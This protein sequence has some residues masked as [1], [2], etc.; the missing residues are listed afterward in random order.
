MITA[1]IA[2]SIT[3]P[4]TAAPCR[5]FM[6]AT[7]LRDAI[8]C[9]G[10]TNAHGDVVTDASVHRYC[11]HTN[12][13]SIVDVTPSSSSSSSSLSTA[14]TSSSIAVSD[15]SSTSLPLPSRT[16]M[17]RSFSSHPGVLPISVW[18]GVLT[19]QDESLWLFG[20]SN[21]RSGAAG[22]C[23]QWWELRL[24]LDGDNV[25]GR[26]GT[27]IP[28]NQLRGRPSPRFFAAAAVIIIFACSS[29]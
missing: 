25:L 17:I 2:T 13:W 9:F 23:D 8:Y 3:P 24:L 19:C 28:H 14:A 12:A 22:A 7:V 29:R 21:D 18:G 20:G 5:A 27:W 6:Q 16:S 15:V 10:G 11:L 1:A 4:H 26:N